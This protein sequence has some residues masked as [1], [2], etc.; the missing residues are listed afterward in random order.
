MEQSLTSLLPS[1]LECRALPAVKGS[2]RLPS[3]SRVVS[4]TRSSVRCQGWMC[5]LS[6]DQAPLPWGKRPPPRDS[7]PFS[8]VRATPDSMLRPKPSLDP[9]SSTVTPDRSIPCRWVLRR[10]F[11]TGIFPVLRASTSFH[12]RTAVPSISVPPRSWRVSV[13]FWGVI[14]TARSSKHPNI[15]AR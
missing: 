10:R 7:P 14:R 6:R 9:S 8:E 2:T 11:L 3:G 15:P 4:A 13:L 12:F 1:N 5:S